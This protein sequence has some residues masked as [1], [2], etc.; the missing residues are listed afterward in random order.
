MMWITCI[1]GVE[2]PSEKITTMKN[3]FTTNTPTSVIPV[4][5]FFKIDLNLLFINTILSYPPAPQ[6]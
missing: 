3:N 6:V 1:T 5:S 2:K 4:L